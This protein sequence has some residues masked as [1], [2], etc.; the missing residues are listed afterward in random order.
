MVH[1]QRQ[2]ILDSERLRAGRQRPTSW[3]RLCLSRWDARHGD[4]GRNDYQDRIRASHLYG[5]GVWTSHS[6]AG[7][8]SWIRLLVDQVRASPTCA[9]PSGRHGEGGSSG[10]RVGPKRG[11]GLSHAPR[12]SDGHQTSIQRN[13]VDPV[14]AGFPCLNCAPHTHRDHAMAAPQLC[15]FGDCPC[16]GLKLKV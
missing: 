8:P 16:P 15:L 6:S 10:G 9:G 4:G 13:P 5:V 7:I 2:W 14:R 3:N 12:R 1:R 11:G